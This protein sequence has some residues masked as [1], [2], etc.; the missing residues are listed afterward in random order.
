VGP[1]EVVGVRSGLYEQLGGGAVLFVRGEVV[2]R[3]SSPVEA[4]RVAAELVRDG[5]VLARGEALAG[6]LPT[7]EEV[8][9]ATDRTAL[10]AMSS[11]ARSRVPKSIL[12]GDRVGFLV[13]L[14]DAP[15]DVSGASVRVRAEVGG[16]E[17]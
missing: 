5:Q 6:A 10:D 15:A 14:G 7:P 13:V 9:K 17:K 12:P 3:A 4:V 16:A 1:F 2:S 8:Y 11:A